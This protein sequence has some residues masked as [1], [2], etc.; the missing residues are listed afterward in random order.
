VSEHLIFHAQ[1][2]LWAVPSDA[3]LRLERG[4]RMR[5]FGVVLTGPDSPRIFADEIHG[6]VTNLAV[7][8]IP[9]LVSRFWSGS[10]VGLSVV[11]E[12][13]VVVLDPARLPQSLAS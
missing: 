2:G 10:G 3:I 6:M 1:G 4:P 9:A 11:G 5:G 12:R 8:P 7:R 13:A